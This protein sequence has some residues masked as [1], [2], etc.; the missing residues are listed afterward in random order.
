[1]EALGLSLFR[2]ATRFVRQGPGTC[3]RRFGS[4]P[5]AEL[6]LIAEFGSLT[7]HFFTLLVGEPLAVDD[8]FTYRGPRLFRQRPGAVALS[9]GQLT[10]L[11]LSNFLSFTNLDSDLSAIG[12]RRL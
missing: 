3:F 5:I 6:G 7:K 4:L 2:E 1:L 12:L 9:Q 10:G 8:R 11:S